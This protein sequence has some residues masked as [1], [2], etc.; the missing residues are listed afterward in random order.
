MVL[1]LGFSPEKAT[2][3]AVA[4]GFPITPCRGDVI[5]RR[6]CPLSQ[7]QPSRLV[8]VV[9]SDYRLIIVHGNASDALA[10]VALCK[11]GLV[12]VQWYRRG[13]VVFLDT[14]TLGESCRPA[15]GK[16]AEGS[17]FGIVVFVV[18]WWYL[19][20]VGGEVELC[21]LEVMRLGD[22]LLR[23][24]ACEAYGLGFAVVGQT[25]N[26]VLVLSSLL[27]SEIW[28]TDGVVCEDVVTDLYH[29]Q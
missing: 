23:W 28:F 22:Q 5:R 4:T 16:T 3:P 24:C 20:E 12:P 2:D 7:P 9:L 26:V 10:L 1:G 8:V 27:L 14:L 21:S 6:H 17:D 13:L 29:Q 25:S 11:R 15:E 18:L 19:V